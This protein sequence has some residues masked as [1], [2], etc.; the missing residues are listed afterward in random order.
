MKNLILVLFA[1]L[2]ICFGINA[3][4]LS[5][6]TFNQ[7]IEP[8][9]D[10]VSKVNFYGKV[11]YNYHEWN[12]Y[13]ITVTKFLYSPDNNKVESVMKQSI[14]FD[15]LDFDKMTFGE[16]NAE[17]FVVIFQTKGRKSSSLKVDY[18]ADKYTKSP[19]DAIAF[20]LKTKQEADELI[21]KLKDKAF[22]MGLDLDAQVERVNLKNELRYFTEEYPDGIGY[23]DYRAAT[24]S[25]SASETKSEDSEAESSVSFVSVTLKHT[26]GERYYLLI[27]GI[28]NEKC[29][30][31][32]FSF[33]HS[34]YGEETRRY[35]F[36]EGQKLVERN[37]GRVIFTAT[38]SMNGTTYKIN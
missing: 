27:N 3:Q 19:Q 8:K 10:L 13:G 14:F 17:K 32:V 15:E 34:N 25:K 9:G 30:N 37:S 36:C 2:T 5:F 28:E 31:A 12:K 6:E 11:F 23:D 20:T 7:T 16:S 35:T 38:K 29:Q 26:G 4:D 18:E 1:I 22:D 24:Q 33:T 21:S